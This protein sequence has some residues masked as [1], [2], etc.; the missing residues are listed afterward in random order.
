MEETGSRKTGEDKKSTQRASSATK[1]HPKTPSE[2]ARKLR[3]LKKRVFLAD[4]ISFDSDIMDTRKKLKIA[5]TTHSEA[6]SETISIKDPEL[7]KI[8]KE[9][10]AVIKAGS[11]DQE[12]VQTQKV[13]NSFTLEDPQNS[14]S[15]SFSKVV[16]SKRSGFISGKNSLKAV[17]KKSAAK[18][19]QSLRRGIT[20]TKAQINI[21]KVYKK[22]KDERKKAMERSQE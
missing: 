10:K 9:A 17:R 2:E 21:M 18:K 14:Y 20:L 12:V 16:L 11:N 15:M 6:T 7:K 5:T 13:S 3:L 8:I 1:A 22:V 19:I 4:H